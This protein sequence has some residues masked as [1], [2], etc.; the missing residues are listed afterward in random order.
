M[1]KASKDNGKYCKIL[2][3][4]KV[5]ENYEVY[6]IEKI[7]LNHK[8]EEEIRFSY[9]KDIV[10][11]GKLQ[12]EAFIPRPVDLPEDKLIELILQASYK[13]KSIFKRICR[14]A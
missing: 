3:Q 4:V 5:R 6:S 9:Y 7:F 10:R 13:E 1:S 12:K 11:L 8:Y 2:R 14:E